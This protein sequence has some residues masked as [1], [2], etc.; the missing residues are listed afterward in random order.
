[1]KVNP[2]SHTSSSQIQ[3]CLGWDTIQERQRF[4]LIT[5][6][7]NILNNLAPEYMKDMFS[8]KISPYSLRNQTDLCLPKPITN[9]CKRSFM[10]RAASEYN[11]LLNDLRQITFC[12]ISFEKNK[13]ITLVFQTLFYICLVPC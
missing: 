1:M 4:H 5:F 2:Y 10:Y 3:C 13:N 12:F 8:F 9:Y 11:E 6:T 7:H